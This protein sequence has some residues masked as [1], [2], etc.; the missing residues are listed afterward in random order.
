MIQ[1]GIGLVARRDLYPPLLMFCDPSTPLIPILLHLANFPFCTSLPID[2]NQKFTSVNIL[3]R[4][5][6][7]QM[8]HFGDCSTF[9]VEELQLSWLNV[10][11]QP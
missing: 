4:L 11:G 2:P 6:P 9:N 1:G 10:K 5:F 7:D 3:H 8:I